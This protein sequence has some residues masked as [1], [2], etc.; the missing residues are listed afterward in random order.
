V[1][2]VKWLKNGFEIWQQSGKY[3]M[4]L[5]DQVASL[6]I[7]NFDE[8]DVGE[9]VVLLPSNKERS[10]PA[11]VTLQVVPKIDL[12]KEVKPSE[13]VVLYAGQDLHFEANLVGWPRYAFDKGF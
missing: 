1:P 13:E 2:N 3:L 9:F 4:Y 6:E 10:A 8:R 5:E 11:H 7:Y 12:S